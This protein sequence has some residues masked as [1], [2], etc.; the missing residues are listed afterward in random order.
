M[1]DEKKRTEAL[2][3][4]LL[5]V[6]KTYAGKDVMSVE[7]AADVA[8]TL[9]ILLGAHIATTCKKDHR[10]RALAVVLQTTMSTVF[11]AGDE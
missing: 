1:N 9:A 3:N 5:E 7:A 11:E 2:Y 4:D 6:I 10:V 8:N